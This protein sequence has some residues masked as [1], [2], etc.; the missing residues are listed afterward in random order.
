M[1]RQSAVTPIARQGPA[2]GKR[3]R[4]EDVGVPVRRMDLSYDDRLPLAW[5]DGNELISMFLTA[6]SASLPEG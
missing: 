6:F 1:T 4:G 2:K 5:F 3:L